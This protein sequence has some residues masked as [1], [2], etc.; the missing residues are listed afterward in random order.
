MGK[1]AKKYW[2]KTA[3]SSKS[4]RCFIARLRLGSI[5]YDIKK[6]YY[7]KILSFKQLERKIIRTYERARL[8][9]EKRIARISNLLDY[10]WIRLRDSFEYT[11]ENIKAIADANQRIADTVKEGVAALLRIMSEEPKDSGMDYTLI[12]EVWKF[13][14]EGYDKTTIYDVLTDQDSQYELLNKVCYI[15]CVVGEQPPTDEFC[16]FFNTPEHPDSLNWNY[17]LDER[18]VGDMVINHPFYH[19]YT[20]C[21]FA[22]Q[23]IINVEKFTYKI[24]IEPALI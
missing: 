16:L 20:A 17:V 2:N 6:F 15:N 12:V 10:R 11:P 1:L 21:D 23:D 4:V 5:A 19:L 7:C 14:D 9:P 8:A 24:E 3:F 22:V 18:Y 13:K